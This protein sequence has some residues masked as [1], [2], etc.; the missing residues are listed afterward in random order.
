MSPKIQHELIRASAGTGKTYEL[1]SRYLRLLQSNE[2]PDD[3]LASTFTRKAAGEIRGRVLLRL[4]QAATDDIKL[5]ELQTALA[6]ESLTRDQCLAMLVGAARRLH[7]LRIGTLDSFFAQL[8]GSFALEIGLRPGWRIAEEHNDVALRARAIEAMLDNEDANSL[9][10]LVHALTRGETTRS[11]GRELR[12]KVNSLYTVYR[13]SSRDAWHRVP[14]LRELTDAQLDQ[15]IEALRTVPLPAHKSWKKSHSK[16]VEAVEA[17]DWSNFI[18]GGISA[19]VA[20]GDEVY[21]RIS[22]DDDVAAA[23]QPLIDHARAVHL[24]QLANQTEATF[25]LLDKFHTQY[26]QLKSQAR[27]MRFEDIT[28]QLAEHLLA[29]PG[30]AGTGGNVEH[31]DFRLDANLRHLLLDEFQDTSLAQWSVI[32]PF[33][34]QITGSR[35]NQSFFCVG[36]TKQAIYGW[37]GGVAEIFDTVTGELQNVQQR[38][39]DTS[40]RSSPHV[41]G[42]INCIFQNLHQH[43]N[44]GN[45]ANAVNDWQRLFNNHE[46]AKPKQDLNGYVCLQAARTAKEAESAPQN[47]ITLRFV[48]EQVAEWKKKA[49]GFEIGVLVRRNDA[50]RRVIYELRELGIE[51]S[52]EGGSSLDDSAAVRLVLSWMRLA[53]HPNDLV[54]RFHIATSPLA[55]SIGPLEIKDN[56]SA[57]AGSVGDRS[58]AAIRFASK[59]GDAAAD[60]LARRIRRQIMDDGYGPIVYALACQLA[61]SCNGRELRRLEKLVGLAYQYDN[62]ATSRPSNFV[63]YVDAAKVRDSISADVRVM[64][65]H[66]AKGL[67][68][69][70]V[71]LAE[72]EANL[73][74]QRGDLVIGRPS[75]TEPIERVCR[76]CGKEVQQLMPA[77]WQRLFRETDDQDMTE[78]LCVLYVAVTRAVH[79]LHLI[80]APSPENE[81]SLHK[82]YGGLLRAALTDGCPLAAEQ[83]AYEA[84][85]REWFQNPGVDYKPSEAEKVAQ[86]GSLA[87]LEVKLAA[88]TERRWRGFQRVSPSSLEGGTHVRISNQWSDGGT[89]RA[90]AL[91]RGTVIHAWFEQIEWLD[92]GPPSNNHLRAVAASLPDLA[93]SP[94]TIDQLLADF[95]T[96]ITDP[97]IAA[98]LNRNY[99]NPQIKL[100]QADRHI[101][102]RLRVENERPIAVRDGDR[103][104]VGNIDRLITLY[105]GE[106]PVAADILDF[107]TDVVAPDDQQ[108][109]D[110]KSTFY[111]PQLQAY[112]QAACAMMRIPDE[113]VQARLLFLQ[114]GKTIQI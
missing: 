49:P 10:T 114:I 21:Y 16:D 1:T 91:A 85:D 105:D 42:A 57:T 54:A 15:A 70:I 89:D 48:A 37:R 97:S 22:I 61:P 39:L 6:D 75:P 53:D 33:A 111:R 27:I 92:E 65:V 72:L 45:L 113:S 41:I 25:Q 14:R 95:H 18:K 110:A 31:L 28:F 30:R 17:G 3:I 36:D 13:E 84:G 38:T 71:L 73:I 68:F 87:P 62:M 83:V 88:P 20:N 55:A 2:R 98:C 104:L 26:Q 52:E 86:A 107:K 99:Y 60:L 29:L 100:I 56:T 7:R 66:Q 101:K 47:D 35:S 19:K 93:L 79:V 109:L 96:M 40:W 82:T 59:Q 50:V 8:A 102:V 103:L 32:R 78:S 80:V 9:L 58:A 5:A 63:T 34:Q 44:L 90:A 24:N 112:R 77:P 74:G 64:P 76:R 81:R 51:A 11:L 4:A 94:E 12:D 108:A 23:Y 67:E 43:D 69:D 106:H 46:T